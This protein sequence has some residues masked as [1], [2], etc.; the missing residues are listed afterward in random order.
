MGDDPIEG[1][2]TLTVYGTSRQVMKERQTEMWSQPCR[3]IA[4]LTDIP[5]AGVLGSMAPS[6]T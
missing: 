3:E 5:V 1:P 2:M 4:T 6:L